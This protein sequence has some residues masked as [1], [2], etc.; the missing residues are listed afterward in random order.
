MKKKISII[1]PVRQGESFAETLNSIKK[2]KYNL[3]KVE[4]I[5]VFGNN[6]SRQRN[7]A[8]EKS[9]GNIIYFIDNDSL[10]KDTNLQL[11]EKFY[12]NFRNAGCIGGPS[13]TPENDSL[14]QK[15]VGLVFG[16]F[17]GSSFSYARYKAVGGFRKSNELELILCN[18]AFNK[19]IFIKVGK[20]NTALYPNE[21]NELLNK[22]KK[23]N[24][25]VYY[26][27]GLIVYR[28]QR[29]NIKLFIKQVF[30]YG[31]GRAEQ[32]M[33]D[34]KNLTL[35]PL[36]SIGFNFYLI[37]LVLFNKFLFF[38]PLFI[39]FLIVFATSL[40][41]SV[42]FKKIIY[43][44]Y[45]VNIYFLIHIFYGVGFLWGFLKKLFVKKNRIKF[46]YKIKKISFDN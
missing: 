14:F 28:S 19:N 15:A 4:V 35:F 33:T 46:W 45:M 24:I 10:I 22:L 32:V 39:Y 6:P 26:D 23:N 37:S 17:I 31:R 40:F 2:S 34:V 9:S 43:F 13:L 18:M 8:V 41:Y 36:I 38:L 3:K 44:F 29:N 20:F 16:S 42:K 27:P 25:D 30:T 11:I 5:I 1:I 7:I 21:E 12:V